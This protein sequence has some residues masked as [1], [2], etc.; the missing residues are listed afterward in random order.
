MITQDG[1]LIVGIEVDGVVHLDFLLRPRFVSDSIDAMEDERSHNNPAF[2]GLVMTC[3]EITKLGTLTRE[4]ITPDLLM[5]MLDIDM[6]QIM[7]ARKKLLARLM[8]FRAENKADSAAAGSADEG[9][10]LP[11]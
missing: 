5:G 7:E 3:Q 6:Q 11:G 1:T 4:Q 9:R 2:E 10:V 8:T